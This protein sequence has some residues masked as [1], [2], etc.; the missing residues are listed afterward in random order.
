M[1]FYVRKRIKIAPG[2]NLNISKWGLGVSAGVKGFRVSKGPRGTQIN[3]GAKGI[4]Y[5][6]SLGGGRARP[7]RQVSSPA[8]VASVAPAFVPAPVSPQDLYWRRRAN[9][10][11]LLFI[12]GWIPGMCAS[13]VYYREARRIKKVTGRRVPWGRVLAF[14]FWVMTVVPLVFVGLMLIAAVA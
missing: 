7:R 2:L 5:R 12:C 10:A 11:S 1:G 4:Y 9:S 3:A 6:K 14:Q 13:W 8:R